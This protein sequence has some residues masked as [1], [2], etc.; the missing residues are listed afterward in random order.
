MS[1]RVKRKP[2]IFLLGLILTLLVV[3]FIAL[4]SASAI[5]SQRVFDNTYGFLWH[6]IIFGVLIGSVGALFMYILPYRI[7]QKLALPVIVVSILLLLAVFVSSL[8]YE[9]GGANRW[10]SLGSF[11]LQP[12]EF[13]KLGLIIYLA[14]WISSRK[15]GGL[16]NF[17]EGIVPFGIVMGILGAILMFQSDLSTFAVL[18]AI[19]FIMYFVGG[20]YL[21]YLA[22]LGV[23]AT[24]VAALFVYFTPYRL[25]RVLSILNPQGDPLGVGFQLN[26]ALFAIGSGGLFGL[27]IGQSKQNAII[28]EAIGDSIFAIW[29]EE[30]GFL[31][32]IILIT[33]FLLFIWRGFRIAKKLDDRFASL[34]VL[35]ITSWIGIQAFVHIGSVIGLLPITG[36]PLPFISYGGSMMVV[37][38]AGAG[39]LLQISRYAR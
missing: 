2:D 9:A 7:W 19:A 3:G 33:L 17:G 31:G 5:E 4:S 21:K 20:G 22:L 13:A 26:Q 38:L 8:G 25:S 36:I 35:G 23:G 30:T 29:S 1:R 39:L 32:G 28:P 37:T 34:L 11:T 16:K 14:A 6:Q 15:L 24:T 18:F 12:S 27:G 10:I